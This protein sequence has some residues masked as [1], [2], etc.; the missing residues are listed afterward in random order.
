MSDNMTFLKIASGRKNCKNS[1]LGINSVDRKP[2]LK[3]NQNPKMKWVSDER[4]SAG[5]HFS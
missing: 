2:E 5:V 4:A 1:I 3:A